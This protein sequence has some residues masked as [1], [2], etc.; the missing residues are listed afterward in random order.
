MSKI[1]FLENLKKGLEGL[2]DKEI[3]ERISFYSEMI[4]DR[5]ED[6]LS[7]HDAIL[8]L[9]PVNEIILE[10]LKDYPLTK[11]VKEKIKPKRRLKTW[12]IIL[13]IVGSPI[14][15]SILLALVLCFL[16]IY[17]YVW[18]IIISLWALFTSIIGSSFGL[19][20][21]GIITLGLGNVHTG[22]ISIA[23]SL[24]LAGVSILFFYGC[25]YATKGLILLTKKI[26]IGIKK[27]FLKKG[28]N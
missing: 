23:L 28:D 27:I 22:I 19:F 1:T 18:S 20:L 8:S 15:A 5:I 3:S 26:L 25:I 14:W 17:I 9:G 12:E 24:I 4:D 11:L 2:P 7:E 21:F 16:A 10:I 6:G 13:L